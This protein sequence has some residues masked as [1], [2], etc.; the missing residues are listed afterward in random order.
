MKLDQKTEEAQLEAKTVH[1]AKV[2]GVWITK[3][4]I[5]AELNQR[6]EAEDLSSPV[7]H[8]ILYTRAVQQRVDDELLYFNAKYFKGTLEEEVGHPLERA[9][10][11]E[12]FLETQW[13]KRGSDFEDKNAFRKQLL[14]IYRIQAGDKLIV[15]TD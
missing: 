3:S 13:K 12:Y 5:E 7:M 15:F 14:Q 6:Y 10:L 4:E 8:H 9:E 11:C 1:A 2:Y